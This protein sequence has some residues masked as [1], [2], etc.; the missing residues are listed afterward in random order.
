MS[1]ARLAPVRRVVARALRRAGLLRPRVCVLVA[2]GDDADLDTTLHAVRAL[3][4]G[5]LV[6][7]AVAK[8]G[9]AGE[10]VARAHAEADWRVRALATTEWSGGARV[11][12][13]LRSRYVVA[14]RGGDLLDAA[15]LDG[16]L[17]ALGPSTPGFGVGSGLRL[18][19]PAAA[20][21]GRATWKAVLGA[22]SADA[23][24]AEALAR[25]PDAVRLPGASARATAGP[26]VRGMPDSRPALARWLDLQDEAAD[27]LGSVTPLYAAW[28]A[29][30]LAG[31]A[32][33]FLEDAERFDD[34]QWA[35]LQQRV[36][37]LAEAAGGDGLD[38]LPVEA[39]VRVALSAAA[40]RA[41]LVRFVA[42]RRFEAGQF[43][44]T[45]GEGV[46]HAVLPVPADLPSDLRR[47]SPAETALHTSVRRLR[48]VGDDLE[49]EVF[50]CVAGVDL[51]EHRPEV[52]ARLVEGER[53]VPLEVVLDTDRE[54]TRWMGTHHVN[55][56]LGVLRLRVPLA[57]LAVPGRLLLEVSVVVAGLIR[58]GRVAAHDPGGSAALLRP[59]VHGGVSVAA[60]LEP[61]FALVA[62][63]RPPGGAPAGAGP[64]LEDLRVADGRLV[65]RGSGL[66]ALVLRGPHGPLAPESPDEDAPRDT[67]AWSLRHDPWGFGPQPLPTGRYVLA[68]RGG[69]GLDLSEALGDRLPEVALADAYRVVV[70]R[71]PRDPGHALVIALGPPL[72]DDEVGPYCQRRLQEWYAEPGHELDT[73]AV[74]LQ[75]YTGQNATDSPLAIAEELAASRPDLV[76]TWAVADLAARVPLGSATVL[77]RSREWYAALARSRYVVTNIELESWFRRRLGQD[78]LQTFH[79]YPS[80]AMGLGLW[81][82]K[83]FTA[84]R[85]EQQL[86]RT[87]RNW[88]LLLTPAPEMDIHYR[89]NYR[90]DGPILAAGYPRDDAL[91]TP[92]ADVR[93]AAARA[94]LGIDDDTV[95]VLYAPTWRDDQAT[96]F[97]SARM[98][99]HLDVAAAAEA[100]GPG[101]VLLL[102]GHRFMAATGTG[103]GSRVLDVTSYPEINDL[104]LA[105]DA[106]VLDYSSMRFDLA[107]TGRPMVF[108]VPDLEDYATAKR[109]FLYDFAPTAPGPLARSSAQVVEALR[110]LDGVRERYRD[111]YARFNATYNRFQDGQAARRVVARFFG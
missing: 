103:T 54:V 92:G 13:R 2:G 56:D 1:S 34:H 47:L 95:A 14:L 101:H 75:A 29:S 16:A 110:D 76:L 83:N 15:W 20:V 42:D 108:L 38:R 9:S 69:R 19:D 91:V 22:T 78:V 65:V 8:P 97:R 73:T 61:G 106:A 57:S 102:R 58:T 79:G 6:V 41:D 53:V 87:S 84:T 43:P 51:R 35:G 18:A 100:L 63:P 46:V 27:L 98:V 71:E 72:A 88:S 86:D 80:K 109:G 82:Q 68:A 111:D 99:D 67:V 10:A 44:S 93:R 4:R 45:S 37:S 32:Q 90:Y 104:V 17:A 36:R 55:H 85:I 50:A 28:A 48:W 26:T 31:E 62:V 24:L 40:R 11:A 74:Y 49:L 107:L 89:E 23:A 105:A 39:R 94:R 30:E 3:P 66:D 25:T 64:V 96:D 59:R 77:W 33:R 52:G 12:A 81:R 70:R 60:E 5:D 21:F 7:L